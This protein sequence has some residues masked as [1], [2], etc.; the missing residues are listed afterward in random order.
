LPHASLFFCGGL[1]R[2]SLKAVW[3]LSVQIVFVKSCMK[4]SGADSC[5]SLTKKGWIYR[6]LANYSPQ[7][8]FALSF[9]KI[10]FRVIR[11]W[12]S[13]C[14][15]FPILKQSRSLYIC[16]TNIQCMEVKFVTLFTARLILF[17]CRISHKNNIG[18]LLHAQQIKHTQFFF[19]KVAL[20][21]DY[22]MKFWLTFRKYLLIINRDKDIKFHF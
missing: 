19:I 20:F 17:I 22:K 14:A 18:F 1:T 8:F 15:A 9:F 11:K 16:K 2:I 7:L 5:I 4:F 12:K 21:E 10:S 3:N 6:Y 13:N